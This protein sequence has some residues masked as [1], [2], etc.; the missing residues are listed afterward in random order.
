MAR[1]TEPLGLMGASF[2]SLETAG[3]LPLLVRGARPLAPLEWV[4]PVSSAQVK[5]A[6]LLAGVTGHASV[7]VTEPRRS[8]DHTER[9]LTMVGAPVVSRGVEAGWYV[10]MRDPPEAL[11]PLDLHIPGD[12]SSA[13][14]FLALTALGGAGES[15]EIGGVGLNPTRTAYLDVL[16]RMGAEIDVEVDPSNGSG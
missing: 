11:N 7:R 1:V 8:R 15:L 9:L 3:R 4:S 2:R 5:S 13:A 10:E 16:R 6:V 12:V 14:F